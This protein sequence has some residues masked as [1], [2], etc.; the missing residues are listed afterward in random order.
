MKPGET[1]ER[2]QQRGLAATAIVLGVLALL[3]PMQS[4][5][6]EPGPDVG[7]LLVLTACLELFHGFRRSSPA[8]QRSAWIGGAITFGLGLLLINAPFI[9]VKAL[10]LL[11]A[12][13]FAIDAYRYSLKAFR[14]WKAGRS[15]TQDL[16]AALGN[17]AVILLIILLREEGINWTIAIAA[18]LR[19]FGTA[20][21]ILQAEIF[22]ADDAGD[23]A[24]RDLGL[25]DRPELLALAEQVEEEERARG[26]AD[27]GM[28][29]TFAAV[30]FAIHLGR[31]GLDERGLGLFSP[32]L[33][34]A[35]DIFVA[36]AVT[37]GIVLPASLLLRKAVRP[38]ERKGW[39]WCLRAP[40]GGRVDG[41][42]RWL[43][44]RW[45]TRRL[46]FS[47]RLRQARYS[48]STAIRKGL[49][50]GL[51]VAAILAATVPIWGMSWFFDTENW[52]AGVWDSWAASR[53]DTWRAAM[54]H[55]V[56]TRENAAGNPYPTFSLAPP[57][58]ADS[59]D[60]SFL[61]IGDPG[62]GDAS[63]HI[64]RDQI[65][66]AA[67]QPDVR[68]VVIS[69]DVIYPTGAMK[70]Y[71]TNFWLP[72]K[73]VTKPV[74]AIPGNHDWYD[75]LEAFAATFFTPDA[76]RTAMRA[77]I[78]A[79]LRLTS[80]TEN[81]IDALV[82]E[83]SRLRKEYRVPTGY[84][85]G[86]F[87]QIQTGTFALITID[88]GVLRCIDEAQ[89]AWLKSA[90][91][92]A[93]GKL[94]LVIL[95][96]PFYAIGEDQTA[97]RPE[98][99]AIHQLLREH[100]VQ[101]VMAGDTHDL[102]YYIERG[103]GA[104]SGQTMYHF[105]NGGGG[106]YL[107]L[108]TALAR[109]D[110][111]PT[112]EWAFYPAT[113][114]IVAKIDANTPLWKAPAWWWTKQFRSWPFSPEWL[115][116]AFDYNVAPFFQSFI[117]IRVEPSARR[118]RLLPYGVHGRLRWADLDTSPGLQSVGSSPDSLVEWVFPMP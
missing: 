2:R 43:V 60:F 111:M 90:L 117:E 44:R 94:T 47:V 23:T 20:R 53:T 37:F 80:T 15:V 32:L 54:V 9:A 48:I 26:P 68:F 112:R 46:R 86:P 22:T 91:D 93:R 82:R 99:A 50:I 17:L 71:E 84:Q 87:F 103:S 67:N 30:L 42:L 118:V 7:V 58:V 97:L 65:I 1:N 59:A 89:L 3:T 14:A 85:D 25:A 19:I 116:A 28:I 63:Q 8:A 77:R 70:D 74:Y 27:R 109:P 6:E 113:A 29:R 69:S 34:V 96:H 13:W 16:F 76:A 64:L 107:S 10:A 55:A 33:A 45:L 83:A 73:G 36:L 79:D 31:M 101:L 105:V 11:I 62:E 35:G 57:G 106:A 98:F 114:P 72:F 115:S 51:P 5:G 41:W 108:G 52:A 56:A 38:L 12:G 75:A 61:V 102:E 95:G 21:N 40:T 104:D 100:D 24:I 66:A 92:A 39:Q 4:S 78:E 81:H 110:R 49:Q 18:A 88:T